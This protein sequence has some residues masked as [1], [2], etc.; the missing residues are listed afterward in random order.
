MILQGLVLQII[1]TILLKINLF[2]PWY[3]WKNMAELALNNNHWLIISSIATG[4]E[5]MQTRRYESSLRSEPWCTLRDRRE[6]TKYTT[7]SGQFLN[8]KDES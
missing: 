3:S 4:Y 1:Y 5:M 7:L 2:S 8:Q 6:M